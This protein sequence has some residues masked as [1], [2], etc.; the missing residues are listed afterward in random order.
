VTD[1]GKLSAHYEHTILVTEK[2]PEV[3]TEWEAKP[4]GWQIN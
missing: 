4:Y 2:D 3:L 1:D